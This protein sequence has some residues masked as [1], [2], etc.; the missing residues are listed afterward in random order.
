MS[1]QFKQFKILQDKAAMKVT[2]DAC[3]FGAWAADLI[4]NE[5]LIINNLLDIGTGTGLL[6]LMLAQQTDVNID[7]VEI[8]A[9][10]FEQA[11]DN[12]SASPWKDRLTV[13]ETDILNFRKENKYQLIISNPPFFENDLRSV[14]KKKNA[15]KHDSTLTLAGL[16]AVV[17]PLLTNDGCFAVL[18]P[19]HRTDDFIKTAMDS[20]LN[21]L[22]QTDVRQTTSHNF[23]R[24]MLLLTKNKV[25]TIYSEMSIK[26]GDN[27]Y[28]QPFINLLKDY[29]LYL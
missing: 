28:T 20:G 11:K 8:D 2:T 14:D 17:S 29:Y 18:L 6:S 4:K 15:A 9:A 23:F 16:L 27:N 3:L 22:Q 21:I 7:A 24:S 26:G 10:A 13:Y 5:K 1:F 19:Y 25:E 12:F